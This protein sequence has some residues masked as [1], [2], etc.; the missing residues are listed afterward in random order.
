MRLRVSTA[1]PGARFE[2]ARYS[3]SHCIANNTVGVIPL[4]PVHPCGTSND[5]LQICVLGRIMD[6]WK[7]VRP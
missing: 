4:N 2:D 3:T 7:D 5:V 6:G 1:E